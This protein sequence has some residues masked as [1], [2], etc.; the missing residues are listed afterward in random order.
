MDIQA[1]LTKG[2]DKRQLT[3]HVLGKQ[4]QRFVIQQEF[5]RISIGLSHRRSKRE[6]IP[7][8]KNSVAFPL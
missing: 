7:T 5:P 6:S 4:P 8:Q 3:F 1:N 2:N